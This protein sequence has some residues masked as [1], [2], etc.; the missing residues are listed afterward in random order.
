MHWVWIKG[1]VAQEP[2]SKSAA[3]MLHIVKSLGTAIV[4][5][6]P[7]N[8]TVA[9]WEF[10]SQ[11]R[12]RIQ[13]RRDLAWT[14]QNGSLP[15]ARKWPTKIQRATMLWL[16][17]PLRWTPWTGWKLRQS[18]ICLIPRRMRPWEPDI[19]KACSTVKL[20]TCLK[21]SIKKHSTWRPTVVLKGAAGL[22][23]PIDQQV[24]TIHTHIYI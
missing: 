14:W 12:G 16:L 24:F 18:W 21:V 2:N 3:A 23:R 22:T 17:K 8:F 10:H 19:P 6:V 15:W 4:T 1:A 7:H 20:D 5:N 9:F 11:V 13:C